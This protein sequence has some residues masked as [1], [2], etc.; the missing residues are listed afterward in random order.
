MPTETLKEI[1]KEYEIAEKRA[2]KNERLQRILS[3]G[4]FF[5]ISRK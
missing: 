3:K 1:L 2:E 4:P 5:Q